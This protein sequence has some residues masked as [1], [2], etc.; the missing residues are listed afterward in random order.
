M[1]KNLLRVFPFFS[2]LF[3]LS[4]SPL[5]YS[6]GLATSDLLLEDSLAWA[7]DLPV[8]IGWQALISFDAL[9]IF[10]VL[11]WILY[12]YCCPQRVWRVWQKLFVF[13]STSNKEEKPEVFEPK[14]LFL[15]SRFRTQQPKR[16]EDESK[17]F[18]WM[19]VE[20]VK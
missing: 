2:T 13:F 6:S 1:T 15:E 4:L 14:S 12:T 11:A 16:K 8:P 17:P 9:F 10:C 5:L 3:F 19:N 18:R 20:E 7:E